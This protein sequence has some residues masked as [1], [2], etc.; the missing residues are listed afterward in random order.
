MNSDKNQISISLENVEQQYETQIQ[1]YKKLVN[2]REHT[3]KVL[4]KQQLELNEA[5][6]RLEKYSYA[7]GKLENMSLIDRI[8][9]RIPHEVKQLAPSQ[10]ESKKSDR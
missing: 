8:F 10:D 5:M 3:Q 9:N 6:K 7:M 1:E 2:K 4:N